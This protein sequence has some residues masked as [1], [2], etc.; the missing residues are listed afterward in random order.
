MRMITRKQA[1][2]CS[3]LPH[4][5]ITE[6]TFSSERFFMSDQTYIPYSLLDEDSI[7]HKR[8]TDGARS[9]QIADSAKN[10]IR[11]R[12]YSNGAWRYNLKCGA[13]PLYH[14]LVSSLSYIDN[15]HVPAL[16]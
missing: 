12:A 4:V 8:E 11:K 13:A 2:P 14:A 5:R 7:A 15:T 9:I 10:S 16:S 1:A 6:K 3:A